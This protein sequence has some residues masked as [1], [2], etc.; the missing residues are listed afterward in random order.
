M[1]YNDDMRLPMTAKTRSPGQRFQ[2][3]KTKRFIVTT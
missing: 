2:D 3:V 1:V